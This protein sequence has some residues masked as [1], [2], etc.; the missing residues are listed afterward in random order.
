MYEN[1]QMELFLLQI[2]IKFHGTSFSPFI[3]L[4]YDQKKE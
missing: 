2:R 4:N 3:F 1:E